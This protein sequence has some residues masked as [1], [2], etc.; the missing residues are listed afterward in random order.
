MKWIK[1]RGKTDNGEL[2]TLA[3]AGIASLNLSTT[4]G[5]TDANGNWHGLVSSWTDTQG[6]THQMA[7]VW[8]HEV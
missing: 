7:D 8:L 4:A 5:T 2:Q 1:H 6:V 3:Q